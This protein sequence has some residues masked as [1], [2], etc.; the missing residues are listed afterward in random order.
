MTR[1]LLAALCGLSLVSTGCR[2]CGEERRPLFPRI[3]AWLDGDDEFERD[4]RLSN[5]GTRLTDPCQ[6]TLPVSQ[7]APSY[8]QPTAFNGQPLSGHF[9]SNPIYSGIPNYPTGP[10]YTYPSMPMTPTRPD[11]LPAPGS[12]IAPPGVPDYAQPKALEPIAPV[13]NPNFKPG[14][15]T[16]ADGKK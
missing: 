3:R 16:T 12:Y 14:A 11:E 13:M 5:S 9:N 4:P 1:L 8:G 10:G 7:T 15:M 2:Q 6:T